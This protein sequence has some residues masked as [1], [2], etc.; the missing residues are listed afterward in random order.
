MCDDLSLYKGTFYEEPLQTQKA[1]HLGTSSPRSR[2]PRRL[3]W[4][5]SPFWAS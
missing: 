4:K 3:V 1:S 5:S 2:S